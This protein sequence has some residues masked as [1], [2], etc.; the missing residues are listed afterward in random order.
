M[1]MRKFQE[2]KIKSCDVIFLKQQQQQ[3]QNKTLLLECSLMP[4]LDVSDGSGFTLDYSLPLAVVICLYGSMEKHFC[5][6]WFAL[7]D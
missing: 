3:Q 4:L 6:V 1:L 7:V 5:Q 2:N